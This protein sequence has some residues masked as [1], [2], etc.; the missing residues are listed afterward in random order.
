MVDRS[1]Q[2]DDLIRRLFKEVYIKFFSRTLNLVYRNETML[3]TCY[4]GYV[5]I[6]LTTVTTSLMVSET[7]PIRCS[8][9]FSG[10]SD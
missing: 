10:L 5:H 3:S 1:S 9:K 2:K 4:Y 6:N 8:S 7:I